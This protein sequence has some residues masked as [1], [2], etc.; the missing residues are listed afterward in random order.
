MIMGE[1]ASFS[2]VGTLKGEV[3]SELKIVD[4][5]FSISFQ[6]S[7]YFYFHLVYLRLGLA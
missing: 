6:F 2:G 1:E 3:M 4:L 7:F 5:T